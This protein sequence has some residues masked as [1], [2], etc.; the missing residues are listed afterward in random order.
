M[1]TEVLCALVSIATLTTA[2]ATHPVRAT[3]PPGWFVAEL[4]TGTRGMPIGLFTCERPPLDDHDADTVRFRP[5]R[6]HGQL[7]CTGGARPI[8]V[9]DRTVGCQR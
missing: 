4:R 5:G 7:Y 6:L 1:V 9:S 8:R 3:C 2:M